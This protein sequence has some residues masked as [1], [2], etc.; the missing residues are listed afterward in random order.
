MQMRR[1]AVEIRA[2]SSRRQK[3]FR[4]LVV[5]SGK[6]GVGKT[7]VCANLA[8]AFALQGRRVSIL[9]ANLGLANIDLLFG[10]PR[11]TILDVLRA[12]GAALNSTLEGLG[13]V[14]IIP[15]ASGV[16]ELTSVDARDRLRRIADVDDVTP[17]ADV[18][19]VD[20]AAGTS[21]DL[22]FLSAP[23]TEALVVVT[24]EPTALTEAYGLM[25]VLSACHG[26]REFLIV[27][28]MAADVAAA[29]A[30]FARLARLAERFLRVRLE[31]VGYILHD[32]AIADAVRD[33]V[34]VVL[35][36]PRSAASAAFL[37]LAIRLASRPTA[38][39][40]EGIQC[41]FR[42]LVEGRS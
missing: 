2:A 27:V 28:N 30:A 18:L 26:R 22:L 6:G 41:F 19:L 13:G 9:D 34:P 33:R 36:A 38:V 32:G 24:P 5:A 23:P 3:P 16:E 42:E 20:T 37:G 21:S 15:G 35:A 31:Y 39:R 10:T 4:V 8:V 25:K 12:D 11:L 17:E 40:T 7:N 29:E 1:H 14:R